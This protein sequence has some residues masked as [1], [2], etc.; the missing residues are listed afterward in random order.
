LRPEAEQG[1]RIWDR[2]AGESRDLSTAIQPSGG[3]LIAAQGSKIDD[4]SVYPSDSFL[5]L[6]A[7]D[8]IDR[9]V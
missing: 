1:V 2:I 9:T 4:L 7:K 3:A 5:R 6:P 8:G